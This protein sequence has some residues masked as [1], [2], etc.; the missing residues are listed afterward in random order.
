MADR[1][2]TLAEA[3]GD[4]MSL[5]VSTREMAVATRQAGYF[6][7]ALRLLTTSA[8]SLSTADP[9]GLAARGCLLLTVAY[10][11]AKNGN[12]CDAMELIADAHRTARHLPKQ[13]PATSIFAP[14]QVPVYAVSVHNALGN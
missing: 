11:Q 3:T 7:D 14:T 5:A 13:Q 2:R 4:P 6:D 10:T 9:D 8:D 12:S 1:A